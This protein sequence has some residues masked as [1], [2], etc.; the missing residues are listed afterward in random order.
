MCH[1]II[2]IRYTSALFRKK[3]LLKLL[4]RLFQ[5][6]WTE[7]DFSLGSHQKRS[8]SLLSLEKGS[9]RTVRVA[10]LKSPTSSL[11]FGC[12]CSIHRDNIRAKSCPDDRASR[13]SA[14]VQ[15][16]S[17]RFWGLNEFGLQWYWTQP[18]QR[19]LFR[20]LGVC[21]VIMV[22]QKCLWVTMDHSSHRWNFPTF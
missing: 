11:F 5:D 13:T 7:W 1:S 14:F 17:S 3:T 2:L 12:D 18:H 20:Y 19:R 6:M 22:C 21:L 15:C 10:F 4:P 16:N 8:L 9:S